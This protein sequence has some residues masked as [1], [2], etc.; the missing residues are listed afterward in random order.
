MHTKQKTLTYMRTIKVEETGKYQ[1]SVLKERKRMA[2][3]H[4]L[5]TLATLVRLN[6]HRETERNEGN[7]GLE[8][9]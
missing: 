3:V 6:Q 7:S 9:E 2:P 4:L 8:T 1:K 5:P